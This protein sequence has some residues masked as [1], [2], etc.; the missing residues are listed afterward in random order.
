MRW[1]LLFL[2][3][4]GGC[5]DDSVQPAIEGLV[6]DDVRP[7]FE[8]N[9]SPCHVGSASPSAGLRLEHPSQFVSVPHAATGLD[10]VRPGSAEDSYVWHKM[11][12]THLTLSGGSGGVMPPEGVIGDDDLN[13]V[14]SWILGGAEGDGGPIPEE[15]LCEVTHPECDSECEPGPVSV[16]HTDWHNR[17][18]ESPNIHWDAVPEAVGYEVSIGSTAGDD[19]AQCWT[20]V[21]DVTAHTF[22]AIWVLEARQ[23][24]VANVRAILPGDTRS[25][26]TS[27]EGWTVDI[28]PPQ[29]PTAL[30]DGR[31][32]VDGWASWDHPLD[33]E[34]AGFAGFEAAIGTSPGSDDALQWTDVGTG[35]NH[36]LNAEVAGLP[37]SAWYWLSL[38]ATDLAGNKSPSATSVGF[39]ICPAH[40]SFVAADD[41]LGSAP[42]CVATYE[43]RIEGNDNGSAGY[44]SAFVPDSRPTG[45]PWAEVEKSESRVACD[46]M[47]FSYQLITNGQWQAIARSIERTDSNWSGGSVGIGSVPQGHSDNSP[48]RSLA[49]DGDPCVGTGNPDCTDPASADFGQ[50][51]THDLDN[52]SV[53]WD[54]SGNLAE[55]VDGSTGGP[56]GYWMSF[57]NDVFTTD[58]GWEDFRENFAPFGD[59]TEVQ[60]MGQMYGGT[61]NLTRGGAYTSGSTKAGWMDT[62]I[63][64]AHHKT[65]TTRSTHGFRCVF[66]P[67]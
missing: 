27:S 26:S 19:D 21:G 54:F 31:M 59:Y 39:I 22:R 40:F 41:L 38:R 50:R 6:F 66:V 53:I 5:K 17:L 64:Q 46:A 37:R 18:T 34:G 28:A 11:V 13:I 60:G 9:C 35:L 14:R 58:P 1:A 33:D 8:S 23:T 2:V 48:G 32:P 3:A 42:F 67:M 63:Y 25:E 24:Y 44:S 62:G 29:V 61:G 51:R 16:T 30:D 49:S 43:M 20:E 12:D 15:E 57:D 55:Q 7:I 45:T 52:G 36:T 4:C 65:H 56:V 47:G 10:L